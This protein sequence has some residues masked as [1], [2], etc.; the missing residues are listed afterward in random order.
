V[1]KPLLLIFMGICFMS[2]LCSTVSAQPILKK[3]IGAEGRPG[4]MVN[5]TLL[6]EN[7]LQVV[8]VDG[9][10]F[11][12]EKLDAIEYKI[13]SDKV[14]KIRIRIPYGAQPGRHKILVLVADQ[15]T[16]M[17]LEPGTDSQNETIAQYEP[18]KID[19]LY[20]D[21]LIEEEE[22]LSIDFNEDLDGSFLSRPITLK[23]P[24]KVPIA[25]S[26][27]KLPSELLLTGTLPDTIPPEESISFQLQ[28][29]SES[30]PNFTQPIQFSINNNPTVIQIKGT[31]VLEYADTLVIIPDSLAGWSQ[32]GKRIVLKNG[33]GDTITVSQFELPR[34]FIATQSLPISIPAFDSVQVQIKLDPQVL[35][36]YEGTLQFASSKTEENP[37]D[38]RI[39]T[40]SD[41][42]IAPL[43]ELTDEEGQIIQESAIN[44]GTTTVGNPIRKTLSVRNTGS[45][46]LL[47]SD[48]KL[49]RG[50]E[51][52]DSFPAEVDA[53][54]AA[55]YTVELNAD[56][57]TTFS[58][59]IEFKTNI[60]GQSLVSLP[61]TGIVNE[62]APEIPS[63]SPVGPPVAATVVIVVIS[64]TVATAGTYLLVKGPVRHYRLKKSFSGNPTF[65]I[66]PKM[67]EG[68]QSVKHTT[69]LK[70]DFE[71]RLRPLLDYGKQSIHSESTLIRDE[72]IQPQESV[73]GRSD[74]LTRIEGIGPVISGILQQ[75]GIT[76]FQK[77][78]VTDPKS[79]LQML[80]DSGITGIADPTTWPMQ[81]ELAASKEW[82]QLDKLQEELKGGRVVPEHT[83]SKPEES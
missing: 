29:S 45:A 66:E 43:L 6:G 5:L 70:P 55:T 56:S 83:H 47:L 53:G 18:P 63:D 34:G 80:H 15:K 22:P 27:F 16:Q 72:V 25:L 52:T 23:N 48:L 28:L 54:E 68:S 67:D 12:D 61:V 4:E 79:I 13:E 19:I 64:L 69:P 39:T 40:E 65:E 82:K 32:N 8:R 58:G 44:F 71:V 76:T 74:D 38:Y 11:D 10:R 24:G 36:V 59:N 31:E 35:N 42:E 62:L 20:D 50:F 9:V 49:P 3:I 30:P 57:A 21:N 33:G 41:R 2:G 75:S 26:D 78:A 14:I 1:R 37:L 51:L 73:S 7:L 46:R 81:A 77:L 60:S 17:W